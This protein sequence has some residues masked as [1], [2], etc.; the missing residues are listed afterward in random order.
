MLAI[1]QVRQIFSPFK[2]SPTL[3]APA[4]PVQPTQNKRYP[5]ARPRRATT[6]PTPKAALYGA[7]QPKK[8]GHNFSLGSKQTPRN[9][10]T[11]KSTPQSMDVS[12]DTGKPAT[13]AINIDPALEQSVEHETAYV[14]LK[15]PR[16]QIPPVDHQAFCF[17]R[18]SNVVSLV[19]NQTFALT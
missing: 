7:L 12:P 3:Q 17:G 9:V 2:M 5:Y 8:R 10:S 1:P 18:L 4:V 6:R 19:M 15:L 11:Y 16:V 14:P 13:A